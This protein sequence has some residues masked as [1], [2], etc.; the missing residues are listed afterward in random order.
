MQCLSSHEPQGWVPRGSL[1]WGC[2]RGRQLERKG[3]RGR[4][5][6]D[7]NR[8]GEDSPTARF[9]ASI[10]L[11]TV[12]RNAFLS[13]RRGFERADS[14]YTDKLQHYTSGHSTYRGPPPGLGV[15]SLL[16]LCSCSLIPCVVREGLRVSSQACVCM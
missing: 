13:R 5:G 4:S 10:S 12:L 11:C 3:G 14:E 6:D 1:C 8:K 9:S 15:R 7:G 2:A 16:G